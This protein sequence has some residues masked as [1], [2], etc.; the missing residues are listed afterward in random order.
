MGLYSHPRFSLLC[1]PIIL[2]LLQQA[3]QCFAISFTSRQRH[4][5]P[6]FPR[7]PQEPQPTLEPVSPSNILNISSN[8][9]P[10]DIWLDS[11]PNLYYPSAYPFEPTP[12]LDLQPIPANWTL[13]CP[14]PILGVCEIVI[15]PDTALPM[16]PKEKWVHI[17]NTEG[18]CEFSAWVPDNDVQ[19]SIKECQD[20]G[21][22]MVT[23]V[24]VAVRNGTRGPENGLVNRASI[25]VVEF[26]GTNGGTGSQVDTRKW[27]LVLQAIPMN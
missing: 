7:Q 2:L 8:P 11:E 3:S 16:A 18:G 17:N 24:A 12:G 1:F 23:A 26:D 10:T 14:K 15:S 9:S 25:N 4:P 22:Q 20:I 13:Y 5:A 6:L 21:A 27:S 19:K